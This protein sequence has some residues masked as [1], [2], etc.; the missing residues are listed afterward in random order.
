MTTS[1]SSRSAPA[2]TNSSATIRAWQLIP[3]LAVQAERR[4]VGDAERKS[5]M[6]SAML[7]ESVFS[8]SRR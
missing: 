4:D 5:T 3:A 8:G 2:P 7:P 6:L 1:R